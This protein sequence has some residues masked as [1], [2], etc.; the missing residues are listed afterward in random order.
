MKTASVDIVVLGAGI[1]GVYAALCF[2]RRGLRV[3][4]VDSE[5]RPWTKASLVNQARVHSGYH[6]PRSLKTARM[7][8]DY[9]E[10][11]LRENS[12]AVN[13][14]F[15]KY[16]AIDR[17]GSLTSADQ[18][19]RFCRK[20]DIPL[21]EAIRKDLFNHDRIEALFEV[22]EAS[23]DPLM[24]RTRYL[25]EIEESSVETCFGWHLRSVEREGDEWKIEL[26]CDD[27][28]C[29]TVRTAGALNATYASLNQL[30]RMFTAEEIPVTHEL[31]EVVLL[32]S[33]RL[34]DIGLT[35]MDGPYVSMMP[36]GLSGLHSLTSVLYTH[37][38]HSTKNL[39]EFEC[40]NFRPDCTPEAVRNCTSCRV[41]P[42]TNRRKMLTQA[43]QYLAPDTDLHIHGSLYTVK[44]KLRSAFIDDG[45][46]TDIRT[47][48]QKP[49]YGCVFSGKINSIYEIEQL[50]FDA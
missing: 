35:V 8:Y 50:Q 9:R 19:S 39:P 15:T 41:R 31:S 48:R 33:G 32:H 26:R 49:F 43:R 7:A 14:R 38:V 46:P 16:Y 1:F 11:F 42:M 37:L 28:A 4:L 22:E 44:T 23:L 25:A 34:R 5:V 2:S 36:F 45:R 21:K 24:L 40:Q 17:Y 13:S 29:R 10:R 30:N 27:G 18:F 20:V 6:Y 12:F 47:Y 3:L